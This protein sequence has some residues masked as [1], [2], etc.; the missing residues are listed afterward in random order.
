MRS[1]C[2]AQLVVEIERNAMQTHGQENT[3]DTQLEQ[4]EDSDDARTRQLPAGDGELGR[5]DDDEIVTAPWP[6]HRA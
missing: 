3:S 6:P 5:Y 1:C 4:Y 2:D